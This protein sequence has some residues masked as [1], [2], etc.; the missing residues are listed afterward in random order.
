MWYY[1]QIPL[2]VML[3]PIL[4]RSYWVFYI[5]QEIPEILVGL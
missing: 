1:C 3:L 4:N 5:Y 2:Q